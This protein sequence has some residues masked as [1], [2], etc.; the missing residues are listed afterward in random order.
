MAGSGH[1]KTWQK[2]KAFASWK[3]NLT[4]LSSLNILHKMLKKSACHVSHSLSKSALRI[5]SLWTVLYRV[6]VLNNTCFSSVLNS[7]CYFRSSP[8][9]FYSFVAWN[10]TDALR[11]RN[12]TH[13]NRVLLFKITPFLYPRN[14]MQYFRIIHGPG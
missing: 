5:R 10:C 3:T 2:I 1:I 14:F 13:I 6:S 9:F 8:C 4:V 12:W 7:L 11:F